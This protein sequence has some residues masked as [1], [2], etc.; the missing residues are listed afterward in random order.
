MSSF[1]S[2]LGNISC[3]FATYI[4]TDHSLAAI[5]DTYYQSKF[6]FLYKAQLFHLET[7]NLL[8]TFLLMCQSSNCFLMSF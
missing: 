1:Q 6:M 4:Q 5:N 8:K 2:K 7:T 3:F